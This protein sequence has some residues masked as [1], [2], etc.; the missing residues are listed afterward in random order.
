MSA[1]GSTTQRQL[2]GEAGPRVEE[3]GEGV[4]VVDAQG[5]VWRV[6]DVCSGPPH[7]ERGKR[8]GLRPPEPRANYRFFVTADGTERCVKLEAE[9]AITPEVLARQLAESEYVGRSD[10]D[11]AR[12]AP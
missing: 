4:Y 5:A 3:R 7:C 1:C 12:H 11:A 9:R 10:F 6:Y 8:R 2:V